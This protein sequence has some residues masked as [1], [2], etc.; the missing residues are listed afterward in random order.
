MTRGRK[1]TQARVWLILSNRLGDNNQLF[2]LAEALGFPFEAKDL[3]Y[4]Q[5]RRIPFLNAEGLRTVVRRHRKLIEPPWPDLVIAAGY[6]SIPVARYIRRQSQGGAKLVFIGNPRIRIDDFDLQFTTPQYPRTAPNLI[7][8]PF[9][10]GN[11]AKA[12]IPTKEEQRW[13]GRFP[14][15]RRLVAVGGPARHWQLDHEAL[16]EAVRR[17]REREPA[18][19]LIVATS[20]RTS[21]NTRR[22]LERLVGVPHEALVDDFPR[23]GVLLSE[24]DEIYVTADSVSM[25]SEAA[26]TGKPVGLIPIERSLGGRVS[27]ALWERPFGHATL[28]DLANFWNRLEASGLVGTAELPLA[29]QVCDTVERAAGAVRALLGRGA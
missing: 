20:P 19:S 22:F 26:L 10:I 8:L 14:R 12:V 24:C 29:S 13:L 1:S 17:L 25:L 15:P 21:G 27:R 2:A 18:G 6:Q 16:G 3:H 7:E 28:P 9:P 23:F 5:L 4:N 11:P